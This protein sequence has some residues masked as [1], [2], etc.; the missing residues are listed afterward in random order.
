MRTFLFTSLLFILLILADGC[1]NQNEKTLSIQTTTWNQEFKEILPLLGHRNWILVV[2]KAFPLQNGEGIQVVY[3]SDSLLRVLDWVLNALNASTHIKPIVYTDAEL[4]YLEPGQ[5]PGIDTYRQSLYALI[6]E[7]SHKI[8]HDSVFVK[9]GK[10]SELFQI[11]V[12][13][14]D[15]VIPYSSVFLELDC[16]YWGPE[17]E[18]QLRD[19]MLVK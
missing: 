14:T 2:D 10:A 12:L 5:V 11:L 13:K 4:D 9:I 17:Q 19:S 1:V 3:T 8:L 16:R 7:G 18:G 6:G 15:E